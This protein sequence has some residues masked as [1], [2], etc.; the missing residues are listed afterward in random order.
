VTL[1]VS[2]TGITNESAVTQTLLAD[3][4]RI[5]FS[6]SASA[7]SARLIA[8]DSIGPGTSDDSGSHII[9]NDQSTGDRSQIE[10]FGNGTLDISSHAVPGVQIGSLEGTGKVFLGSNNLTVGSVKRITDF[11]GVISDGPGGVTRGSLTIIGSGFLALAGNNTFSGPTTMFGGGL[12]VGGSLAGPVT[13]NGG[14]LN[15]LGSVGAVTVNN[16][17][18]FAPGEDVGT[19]NVNGD[20]TMSAGSTYVA[21]LFGTAPSAQYTQANVTG[22]VTLNNATL[23]VDLEYFP[24]PGEKYTIIKNDGRDAVKGKFA[25]LRE[26]GK[27]VVDGLHFKISYKGGGN[28]VVITATR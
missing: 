27:F 9:F 14:E 15:G 13:I 22:K 18:S 24:R 17:G 20:L 6:G 3:E 4:G 19:L 16:G 28:D 2:G 26:G 21:R 5:I 25:G 7:E 1:T 12:N 23:R 10:L 8:T 11:T